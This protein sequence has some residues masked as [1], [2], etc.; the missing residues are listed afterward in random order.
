MKTGRPKFVIYKLLLGLDK[1]TNDALS[2]LARATGQS[3][4]GAARFAIRSMARAFH[5]SE[6]AL[7]GVSSEPAQSGTDRITN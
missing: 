6:V 4:N 3:P 5:T 2:D 7:Q 1:D